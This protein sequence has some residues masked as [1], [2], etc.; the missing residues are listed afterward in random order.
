VQSHP[1]ISVAGWKQIGRRDANATQRDY[2]TGTSSTD[3]QAT[4]DR[5]L[6]LRIVPTLQTRLDQVERDAIQM[7]LHLAKDLT[8][9]DLANKLG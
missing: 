9:F 7:L 8:W 4:L 5:D 1:Q 6:R 3:S 2:I